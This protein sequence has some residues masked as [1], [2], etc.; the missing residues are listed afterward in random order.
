MVNITEINLD[1]ENVIKFTIRVGDT[2]Q[3]CPPIAYPPYKTLNG[4][5]ELAG[6]KLL[7]ED[8]GDFEGMS[9]NSNMCVKYKHK[10]SGKQIIQYISR[11][12]GEKNFYAVLDGVLV[13]DHG[14]IFQ[15][16]P[17]FATYFAEGTPKGTDT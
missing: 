3:L 6:F 17:A 10:I 16:G 13:H 2:I 7:D 15:G 11:G 8:L 9:A 4:T 14:S 5:K 12:L 1:G